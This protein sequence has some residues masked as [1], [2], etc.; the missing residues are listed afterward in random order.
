MIDRNR[1][2]EREWLTPSHT[3]VPAH[4]RAIISLWLI[5][6]LM[7]HKRGREG[8]G[9]RATLQ[10][11]LYMCS[12]RAPPNYC[13]NE[14]AGGGRVGVWGVRGREGPTRVTCHQPAT[15]ICAQVEVGP[16]LHA[17]HAVWSRCRLSLFP[18]LTLSVI[19]SPF[20]SLFLSLLCASLSCLSAYTFGH[21][22][23]FAL[24]LCHLFCL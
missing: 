22:L 7:T 11:A 16:S 24:S 12:G 23:P 6:A 17:S 13:P 8:G 15:V 2:R 20:L 10:L 14:Q 3:L 21:S 19:I 4:T 9:V 5:T 1:G 18:S